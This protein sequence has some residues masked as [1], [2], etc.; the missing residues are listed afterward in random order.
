MSPRFLVPV[1]P[2][3]QCRV[4][5]TGMGSKGQAGRRLLPCRGGLLSTGVI[6]YPLSLHAC[7]AFSDTGQWADPLGSALCRGF[8]SPAL[9]E[10]GDL[11]RTPQVV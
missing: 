6:L 8:A 2:S 11:Q 9:A 4:S 7:I 1:Y 5:T 10:A 3:L